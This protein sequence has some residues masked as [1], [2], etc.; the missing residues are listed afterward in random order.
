MCAGYTN[1]LNDVLFNT[2]LSPEARLLYVFIKSKQNMAKW[3]WNKAWF[4][5]VSGYGR[6]KVDKALKE[7]EIMGFITKKQI[8][9]GGRYK[10]LKITVNDIPIT[11][12]QLTVKQQHINKENKNNKEI[13]NNIVNDL[14]K[15]LSSCTKYNKV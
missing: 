14:A 13:V 15:K 6:D 4:R 8:R 5:N 10:S 9:Q 12:N 11:E 3:Q 1:I 7:L 2:R